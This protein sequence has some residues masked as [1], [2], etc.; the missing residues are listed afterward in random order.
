MLFT[1]LEFLLLFSRSPLGYIFFCPTRRATIGCCW[2]VCSSMHGGEP[3]FVLVMIASIL[4]DYF[5]ALR[6]EELAAGSV[7]RKF[8]LALVVVFYLGILFVFKYM[9]FVTGTLRSWFPVSE[10]MIP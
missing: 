10:R 7:L 9:N 5:A 1:S 2:P 8:F 6:I 4:F 3:R